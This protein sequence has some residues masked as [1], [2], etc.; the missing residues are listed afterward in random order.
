MS[1]KALQTVQLNASSSEST[2]GVTSNVFSEKQ[3]SVEAISAVWL[4]EKCF[5]NHICPFFKMHVAS[6][7]FFFTQPTTG[8]Y[9]NGLKCASEIQYSFFLKPSDELGAFQH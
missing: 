2:Q 7:F 3:F 5:K 4:F 1:F 8:K 6:T 9:L